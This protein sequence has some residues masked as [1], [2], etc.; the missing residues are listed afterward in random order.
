MAEKPLKSGDRV[1]IGRG[2]PWETHAGTLVAF[3]K[4]GFGAEGWRVRLDIGHEC[5]A[6]EHQIKRT[7]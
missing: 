7:N 5:Y 3:E 6:N 2:H 1:T 4:Y